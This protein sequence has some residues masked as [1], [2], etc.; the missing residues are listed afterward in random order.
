MQPDQDEH[1]AVPR[2]PVV[3]RQGPPDRQHPQHATAPAGAKAQA[4][5]PAKPSFEIYGFT[6]LDVGHDFKQ[7]HPDWYDTM[8]VTKLPADPRK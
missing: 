6:M 4:S 1:S 8:R 5:G 7:I 2:P 3:T